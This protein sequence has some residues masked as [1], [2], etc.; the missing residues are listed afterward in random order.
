MK[1]EPL[2][3]S[4]NHLQGNSSAEHISALD[5]LDVRV[6]IEELKMLKHGWLDGKGL[7]P[8][9]DG[10]DWLAGAFE[11]NFPDDLPPP[12]LYPTAESGVRAE[13]SIKPHELSLEIDLTARTATWHSL[14][15][16]EDT[17]QSRMVNLNNALDWEWLVSEVRRLGGVET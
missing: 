14:N 6:R 11:S 1:S 4:R 17:D 2:L 9:H 5:P 13:W 16:D 10:L 8:S 15:M 7:A 12:Y 3:K